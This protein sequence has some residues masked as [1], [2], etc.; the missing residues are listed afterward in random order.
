MIKTQFQLPHGL[1][2][3]LP[4]SNHRSLPKSCL[5]TKF[6]HRLGCGNTPFFHAI[7]WLPTSQLRSKLHHRFKF[8]GTF[9]FSC[10]AK[11]YHRFEFGGTFIS[12][13]TAKLNHRFS[14]P[15]MYMHQFDHVVVLMWLSG[16]R[17]CHLFHWWS[18]L[19]VQHPLYAFLFCWVSV[20]P[21]YLL[22]FCH[23]STA[24]SNKVRDL[25]LSL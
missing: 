8:G 18:R 25:R 6:N 14:P 10:M 24:L 16:W 15:T 7:W 9:I 2:W 17:A 4:H 5:W 21:Y 23:E 19:H 20:H 11:L 1:L 12:S 13:S 3:S 22:V